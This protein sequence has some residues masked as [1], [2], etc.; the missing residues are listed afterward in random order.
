MISEKRKKELETFLV[1]NN[2]EAR[3][4]DLINASLTHPSFIFEKEIQKSQHNQ[5][6]E[7]LGD[8]VVGLIVGEYLYN[9]F[10]EK[11]EGA[12]TKMR[13]AIVCESALAGAARKINLGRYMLMGNGENMGGG[14]N[15]SSNLADAWEALCGAIYLEKGLAGVKDFI[16]ECL[17][18]AI[19]NVAKGNYG[20]FKTRLQEIIQKSPEQEIEYRILQENGPDHDKD[21]VAGVYINGEK[22]AEG[23]GK[24]KKEAE[25]GAA[26][27]AL[28]ILGEIY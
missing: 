19:D 8:A 13:A 3:N 24:T 26:R 27:A 20:D 15:R 28:V 1:K 18:D 2:V 7:F 4:F 12:L 22:I 23:A 14:E 25:Q 6:L 9:R 21:F 5:R 10:P 11:K 17:W 16:I